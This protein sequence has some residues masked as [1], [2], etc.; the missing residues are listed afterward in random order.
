MKNEIRDFNLRYP[1]V[2]PLDGNESDDQNDNQRDSSDEYDSDD[3][4]DEPR[5]PRVLFGM[6]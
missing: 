2:N 6:R 5:R 4:L 1:F 3:S